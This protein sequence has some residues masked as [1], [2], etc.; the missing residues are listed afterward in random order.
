MRL[1]SPIFAVFVLFV[2]SVEI[3]DAH[4]RY[5]PHKRWGDTSVYGDGFGF[6]IDDD[7]DD[8]DGDIGDHDDHDDQDEH[9]KDYEEEAHTTFEN[10]EHGDEQAEEAGEDDEYED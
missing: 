7:Y 2:F 3:G 8:D 1:L 10:E 4:R 9:V 6:R 5:R